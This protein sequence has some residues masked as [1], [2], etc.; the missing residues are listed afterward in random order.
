MAGGFTEYAKTSS[1][2]VIRASDPKKVQRLDVSSVTKDGNSEQD[3]ELDD[4]D[5]V[6]IGERML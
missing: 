2:S 6:F 3:L 4:G 1:V 5:L